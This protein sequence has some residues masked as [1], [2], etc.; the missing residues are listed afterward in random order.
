MSPSDVLVPPGQWAITGV[1]ITVISS[2]STHGNKENNCRLAT[3]QQ[4]GC[5]VSV[6]MVSAKDGGLNFRA[7]IENLRP[8]GGRG[9]EGGRGGR[10]QNRN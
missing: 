7:N 5:T 4:L 1:I 2:V 9:E 6:R 10:D 8:A 3:G